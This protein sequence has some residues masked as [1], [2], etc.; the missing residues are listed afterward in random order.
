MMTGQAE[1]GAPCTMVFLTR[2]GQRSP[3][4]ASPDFYHAPEPVSVFVGDHSGAGKEW[5][6]EWNASGP[7][8]KK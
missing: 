5:N 1:N 2:P 4:D 3:R 7:Q 6:G 8:W